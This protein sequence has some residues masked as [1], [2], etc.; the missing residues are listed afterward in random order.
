M[1]RRVAV[2]SSV[3]EFRCDDAEGRA[4]LRAMYHA[5]P[6]AERAASLHYALERTADG[7]LALAPGRP[8]FAAGQLAD[9]FSFLEWRATEDVLG[10]E[11]RLVC[12]HAA[13]VCVSGR[14]VLLVGA[15][16]S[17]KSTLAAHL[18]ASGHRSW[19][20][21]LLC[22]ASATGQFSAFPRSFKLDA[23]VLRDIPLLGN[24]AAG[25][26][27]GTLFAPPVWYVSPAAFRQ[28]WRAEDGRA[29]AVVLLSAA[30]HSGA[31]AV[32]RMSEGA[33]AILTTQSLIAGG[34]ADTE[35]TALMVAV[36]EALGG[37]SAW[38][39]RGSEPARLAQHLSAAVG[40]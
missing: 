35:R 7:W 5:A 19:G 12:L 13:G 4:A 40:A 10:A 21:D 24:I 27:E 17:G 34:N 32:E 15:S 6:P 2:A 18:L 31:T 20:D 36:I 1:T 28:D 3:L 38:S 11:R 30:R 25:G 26:Q 16:G 39:A 22:F 37:A 29:D 8:P 9:A 14:N 23:K 33:A